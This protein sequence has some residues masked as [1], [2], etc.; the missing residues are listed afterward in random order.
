MEKTQITNIT[1]DRRDI[2]TDP[3]DINRI[4]KEYYE[5]LFVTD[6]ITWTKWTNSLKDTIC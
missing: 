5:Q 2:T 1:N 6:L 4:V 3:M